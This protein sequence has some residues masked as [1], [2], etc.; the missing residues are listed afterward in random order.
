VLVDE[1]AI[2]RPLLATG[3]DDLEQ[4][5]AD[6]KQAW[7]EDSSNLELRHTR[8]RIRREILPLL[9]KH[10]NANVRQTLSE[11]AEIARAE[12][13]FWTAEIERRLPSVWVPSGSTGALSCKEL[14]PFDLAFRRR[15]VRAAA[16]S[17][18]LNLEFGHVEEVLAL[19]NDGTQ[20]ALPNGWM[21]RRHKDQ[22][23]GWWAVPCAP[24]PPI[25]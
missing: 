7:R 23:G 24:P 20:T 3:R 1:K 11:T 25:S 12:E 17:L 10:V 14:D 13:E 18:G 8:N 15:L 2:V 5:L 6:L 22:R 16:E 9:R 19:L 4:Y 21:A